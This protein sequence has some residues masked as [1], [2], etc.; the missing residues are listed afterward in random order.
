MESERKYIVRTHCAAYN[1][2]LYIR[3]AL[4]GF[5]IQETTF[6]VV[7]TIVDDASKDR[8]ADVIREFV[9]QNFDL[10]DTSIAYE[11]DMDYGHVIFARHKTNI[12]CYF[13]VVFLIEN[14]YSIIS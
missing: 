11:K 4:Q 7:Y 13:A 8:T 9:V 1:H 5:V 3:D 2:E 10:Q 14:H 12:N 6:P